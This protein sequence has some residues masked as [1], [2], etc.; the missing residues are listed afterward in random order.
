MPYNVVMSND[1]F[2]GFNGAG[3]KGENII[4]KERASSYEYVFTLDLEGLYP[5]LLDEG[6]ILVYDKDTDEQKYEI[7]MPFMYDALGNMSYDVYYA[8]RI[9]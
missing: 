1:C 3:Y 5:I 7:P 8:K 2:C 9:F 6:S 4:V